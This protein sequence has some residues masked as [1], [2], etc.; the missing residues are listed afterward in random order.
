M[1]FD[2]QNTKLAV[3]KKIQLGTRVLVLMIKWL[4]LK[5]G[6]FNPFT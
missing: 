4:L 2:N 1:K 3:K 6:D 5:Q